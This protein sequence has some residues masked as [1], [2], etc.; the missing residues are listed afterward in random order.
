MY[1]GPHSFLIENLNLRFYKSTTFTKYK[2]IY[3]WQL[4]KFNV[5]NMSDH[6]WSIWANVYRSQLDVI[7]RKFEWW[8]HELFA[9]I[10]PVKQLNTPVTNSQM[11]DFHRHTA[12]AIASSLLTMAV[13]SICL[14]I[15]CNMLTALSW[16]SS[17]MTSQFLPHTICQYQSYSAVWWTLQTVL[18]ITVYI[19]PNICVKC[20]TRRLAATRACRWHLAEQ[21]CWSKCP[22][23]H[24]TESAHQAHFFKNN[25]ETW[26]INF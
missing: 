5:F 14:G 6:P 4:I 16:V 19:R 26:D 1:F 15:P 10:E 20:S 24:S 7:S 12:D 18:Y 13:C 11:F 3:W 2:H 25:S 8:C 9:F 23:S 17:Q 21:H 22:I